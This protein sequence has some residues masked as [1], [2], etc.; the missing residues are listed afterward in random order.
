MSRSAQLREDAVRGGLALV[1]AAVKHKTFRNGGDTMAKRAMPELWIVRLARG[2]AKLWT[3][4]A[5]GIVAYAVLP[6]DWRAVTRAL[7]A[8]DLGIVLYLIATAAMMANLSVAEIR[9]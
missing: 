5:L 9:R 8:W 7:V 1:I 2:H 4:V 6:D 3:A